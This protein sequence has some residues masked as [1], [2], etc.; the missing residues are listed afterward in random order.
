MYAA[1]E[2]YMDLEIYQYFVLCLSEAVDQIDKAR[3]A[4]NLV[5]ERCEDALAHSGFAQMMNG[6]MGQPQAVHQ[7]TSIHDASA[8]TSQ[9]LKQ[10]NHD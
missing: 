4:F 5:N 3:Q 10:C 8:A 1:A 2:V 9:L 6:T 7:P